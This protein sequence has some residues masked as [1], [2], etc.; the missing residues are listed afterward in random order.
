MF[1]EIN[2][3]VCL[4]A[5]HHISKKREKKLCPKKIKPQ[6]NKNKTKKEKRNQ[7]WSLMLLLFLDI[8]KISKQHVLINGI[9]THRFRHDF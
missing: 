4:S 2:L 3:A 6:E 1:S 8:P 5:A 9:S 7:S